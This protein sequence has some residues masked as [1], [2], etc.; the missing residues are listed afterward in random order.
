MRKLFVL[1][2]QRHQLRD[3][4]LLKGRRMSE[5]YCCHDRKKGTREGRS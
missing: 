5:D 1:V 3:K 2:F 4:R